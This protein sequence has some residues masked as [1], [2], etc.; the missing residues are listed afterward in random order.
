MHLRHPVGVVQ[1]C[2][3]F[4]MAVMRYGMVEMRV[5]ICYELYSLFDMEVMCNG[6]CISSLF[7]IW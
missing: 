3:I 4:D 7:L 1:L 2:D 6:T 5:V